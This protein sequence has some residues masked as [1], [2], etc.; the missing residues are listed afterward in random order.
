MNDNDQSPATKADLE[1]ALDR[2]VQRLVRKVDAATLDAKADLLRTFNEYR[3]SDLRLSH[4]QP[5]GGS[6]DAF[7]ALRIERLEDAVKQLR[8]RVAQLEKQS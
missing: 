6:L 1:A 8:A 5:N 7:T 3:A 2:F 4:M